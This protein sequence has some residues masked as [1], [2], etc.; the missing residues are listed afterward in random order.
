MWE[1]VLATDASDENGRHGLVGLTVLSN[2]KSSPLAALCFFCLF[3]EAS[4]R[5][6]GLARAAAALPIAGCVDIAIAIATVPMR[7]V[8]IHHPDV[9]A[10]GPLLRADT[11]SSAPRVPDCLSAGPIKPVGRPKCRVSRQGHGL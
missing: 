1:K 5:L 9:A 7:L 4:A 10:L 3:G 6:R 8:N 2:P 11:A